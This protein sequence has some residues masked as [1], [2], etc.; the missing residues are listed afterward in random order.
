MVVA[1][2]VDIDGDLTADF[3]AGYPGGDVGEKLLV[4]LLDGSSAE[5]PPFPGGSPAS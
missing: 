3:W 1:A 4:M 2:G 5:R